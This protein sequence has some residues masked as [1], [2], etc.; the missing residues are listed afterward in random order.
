MCFDL[1]IKTIYLFVAYNARFFSAIII[2]ITVI[3][4][5]QFTCGPFDNKYVPNIPSTCF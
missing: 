5:V 3:T 1:S 2:K 4:N